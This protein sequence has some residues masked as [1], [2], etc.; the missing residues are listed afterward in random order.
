MQNPLATDLNHQIVLAQADLAQKRARA[1][2]V[3]TLQR[4]GGDLGSIPEVVSSPI[5]TQLRVRRAQISSQLDDVRNDWER[6][7]LLWRRSKMT[8]RL[9]MTRLQVKS[10]A[11]SPTF[12]TIT[13]RLLSANANSRNRRYDSGIKKGVTRAVATSC[14]ARRTP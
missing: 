13:K 8:A 4:S 10:S 1:E 7:L 11:L 2:V 5:I 14:A 9:W 12:K 6:R 3:S